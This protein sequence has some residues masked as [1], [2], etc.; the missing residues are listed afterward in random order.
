MDRSVKIWSPALS[1]QIVIASDQ[2]A[3]AL[4]GPSVSHSQT[5]AWLEALQRVSLVFPLWRLELL[6]C[7]RV[8]VP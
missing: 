3:T 8:S 6:F 4:I 7:G 1:P 5:D 2:P